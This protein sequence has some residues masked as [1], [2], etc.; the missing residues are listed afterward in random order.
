ME[1]KIEFL[2]WDSDFFSKKIGKVIIENSDD[3]NCNNLTSYDLIYVFSTAPDLNYSLV[4]KKIVYILY[5]LNQIAIEDD[6]EF[7]DE[8]SDSYNELLSL[9]LQ[10]GQYSRF[11]IDK[12]FKNNE[13]EKLYKEWIDGS[14]SKKLATDI[15]VK[16]MDGKLVGFVTLTKKSNELADIGLVAVDKHYRGKGIAKDLVSK[17]IALAKKQ[18]YKQ[19]QVVTQLDNEPANILYK[20]CGFTQF[21]LTYI[22]HIWNHDTI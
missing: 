10:S 19:I 21:S 11:K 12:N 13:Y 16:R 1:C 14:I 3:L 22:Y 4:D 5:D 2:E 20:K 6:P 8:T 7:F 17:T 9:T 18:G 15:I